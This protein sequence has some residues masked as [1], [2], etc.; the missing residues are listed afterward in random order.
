MLMTITS[1][2][3]LHEF[4]KSF[5]IKFNVTVKA[6]A[7]NDITDLQDLWNQIEPNK[8]NLQLLEALTNKNGDMV[9][10]NAYAKK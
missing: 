2:K 4:D 10:V 5:D 8:N 3:I 9:R 1:E 6:T 7:E